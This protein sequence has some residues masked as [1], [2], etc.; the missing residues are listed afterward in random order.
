[1]LAAC[2]PAAAPAA[3]VIEVAAV[4]IGE[5]VLMISAAGTLD[6]CVFN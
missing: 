2:T 3:E 1:M 5:I 6:D 4:N